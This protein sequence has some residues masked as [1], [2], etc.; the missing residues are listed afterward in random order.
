MGLHRRIAMTASAQPSSG[1][2]GASSDPPGDLAHQVRD[3]LRH[4][5]DRPRLQ[6]HQLARFSGP[7][8]D[9]RTAGRGKLLQDTLLAVIDAL[10]P[11]AN[12]P[13]DT[14]AGRSYQL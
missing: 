13:T 7:D 3:A 11:A 1:T 14:P 9:K 6:T 8:A 4:L 2:S 5:H 12:A 10:R